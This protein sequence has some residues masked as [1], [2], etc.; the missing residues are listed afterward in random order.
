MNL[1]RE[2]DIRIAKS[3]IRDVFTVPKPLEYKKWVDFIDNH[4]SEFI[5]NENTKD[6]IEILNA[7]DSVPENFKDRVLASLNK[8]NCYKEYSRK[9]GYYNISIGINREDN[10]ISINFERTPKLEDLRIFVK[11]AKYLDAYLLVEGT[12]IIDEEY[13]E[14]NIK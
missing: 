1:N 2:S 7:I 3:P 4:R 5:W 11:M 6:G 12:Q 14:K 9:K 10:W 8:T 13:L